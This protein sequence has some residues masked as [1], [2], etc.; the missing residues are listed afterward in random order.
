[1]A[2]G[3]PENIPDL[4][5]VTRFMSPDPVAY[6]QRGREKFLIVPGLE[7]DRAARVTKGIEVY[8]LEEFII[9]ATRKTTW[10][11]GLKGL[12]RK[13]GI[14]AV[15]VAREFPVGLARDL[16]RSGFR[17]RVA[18]RELFPE[19]ET[20]RD[21]EVEKIA[22]SQS[23][24]ISA[25]G[26]AIRMIR[27]ASADRS[28]NLVRGSRVLTSEMVR[29]AIDTE[30]LKNNC[31]SDG[32]IVACG[33]QSVEPHERGRGPLR[34]GE[35]IV[36]DIFPRSLAHGYWGDLTRTVVK[37]RASPALRKMHAAVKAAQAAALSMIKP[38]TSCA[39]VHNAVCASLAGRGFRTE[40][41]V[42]RRLGFFHSTGHG[43]G[44]AI[45]EQPSLSAGPGR[46]KEGHV[47][48]VEPGLYYHEIGGVRIEDL[49]LV[50]KTGWRYLG[51]CQKTLEI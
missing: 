17:L 50:T 2:I 3:T 42:G 20:K 44:V 32:T 19:R 12:M 23:A 1:M 15:T 41:R 31:A 4:L 8:S 38:G 11:A 5:Y 7:Y 37:G 36:I 29:R 16:E 43:V 40:M 26:A 25:M 49:V 27:G 46:L 21:D 30:L 14:T 9:P 6:L 22:A 39:A 51:T 45:H 18:R 28:G 34:A 48:T 47:V 24:A 33:P 35:G 10:L 13:K